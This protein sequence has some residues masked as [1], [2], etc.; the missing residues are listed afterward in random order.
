MRISHIYLR[1]AA[2]YA[3]CRDRSMPM[4]DSPPPILDFMVI[5]GLE[6]CLREGF[7]FFVLL[8]SINM[9]YWSPAFF[10]CSISQGVVLTI[11]NNWFNVEGGGGKPLLT[12]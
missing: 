1:W 8:S 10:S 2:E 12:D 7:P 4:I 11:G 9:I 3:A 5:D 6:G